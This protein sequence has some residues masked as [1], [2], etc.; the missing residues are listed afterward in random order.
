MYGYD[1]Y[2]FEIKESYTPET[3]PMERMGEYVVELAKMLGNRDNVHFKELAPGSVKVKYHVEH[4]ASPKVEQR[5]EDI[6]RNEATP[7]AVEAVNKINI[8]LRDD[9]AV[10]YLFRAAANEGF[11]KAEILKFP[12]REIPRPVKIGPMAKW[13]SF[14]GELVRIGGKTPHAMIETAEGKSRIGELTKAMAQELASHLYQ[15]L[16]VAGEARWER[17]EDGTWD[18]KTF[19]IKT[20]TLLPK[21]TLLESVDRLREIEGNEWKAMDDPVGFVRKLRGEDD[22]LH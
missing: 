8:M 6:K 2:T 5:L 12:G 16:R 13:A 14:D 15:V 18:L 1:E 22:E 20:F 17:L 11:P 3:L 21:E 7:E 10:G 19:Y 9:N 4:E